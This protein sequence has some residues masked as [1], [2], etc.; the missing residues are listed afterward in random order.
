MTDRSFL[1]D[2][3]K[4]ESLLL[5]HGSIR[6]IAKATGVPRSTVG[7]AAQ[8]LQVTSFSTCESCAPAYV[9]VEKQRLELTKLRA[10]NKTLA[11]QA[12][13]YSEALRFIEHVD[14][15][16]TALE[17]QTSSYGKP[18]LVS[19]WNDWHYGAQTDA[20]SINGLY[21]FNE[22]IM[23]SRASEI[24]HDMNQ[25]IM[26]NGIE[27]VV[28]VLN[29][30]M[31]NGMTQ[32][33]PDESTDADRIAVQASDCAK[34]V[35]ARFI[36]LDNA[37]PDTNFRVVGG[38]G[39]HTRSTQKSPTSAT[40]YGL[41]W[42][43]VFFEIVK[44][45][46]PQRWEYHSQY[47][48]RSYFEAGGVN[49]VAAHGHHF[50]GGGGAT[51]IP[52]ASIKKFCEDA[53]W[54]LRELNGGKLGAV[55]LGHYHRWYSCEWRNVTAFVAPSPKGPDS[56]GKDKMQDTIWPGY[57]SFVC[58]DGFVEDIHRLRFT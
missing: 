49:W 37:N 54:T 7:D 33:H 34:L 22:R 13:S 42:E 40:D 4:Y 46:G 15:S 11:L 5:E 19:S 21:E 23:E 52:E 45:L 24:T 44:A 48:Y 25:Q 39:N 27:D 56:F 41:S 35:A 53:D 55:L 36:D 8:R 51:H 47:S 2:R 32:L 31:F 26:D 58:R 57:V 20:S 6:G 28:I 30:D 9:S 50:S 3:A 43:M 12:N 38:R 10:V 14:A 1:N 16:A 17:P 29:G 18:A